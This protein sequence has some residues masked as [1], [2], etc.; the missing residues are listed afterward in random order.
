MLHARVSQIKNCIY[1]NEDEFI[2]VLEEIYPDYKID[3]RCSND[4]LLIDVNGDC[5][6][7][8]DLHERLRKYY[9]V[10]EIESI[11]IDDAEAIGIW[12]VYHN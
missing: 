10:Y 9:N 3:V 1:L 6:D 5:P 11:H 8:A 7:T 12:I 4:G 2:S